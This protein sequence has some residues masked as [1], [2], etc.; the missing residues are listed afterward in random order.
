LAIADL[1]WHFGIVPL[2]KL[3][4]YVAFVGAEKFSEIYI[5]L[6]YVLTSNY[7]Y[8]QSVLNR[9]SQTDTVKFQ[10]QQTTETGY[11]LQHN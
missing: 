1:V 4:S 5:T 3:A 11:V 10:F 9:T 8:F 2:N 7:L 6:H